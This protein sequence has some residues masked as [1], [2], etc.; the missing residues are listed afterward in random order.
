MGKPTKADGV[1]YYSFEKYMNMDEAV[2]CTSAEIEVDMHDHYIGAE[3]Q[4][5][6]NI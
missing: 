3:L 1:A 5:P 6:D 2:D 4:I